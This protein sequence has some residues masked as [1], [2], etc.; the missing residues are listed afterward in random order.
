MFSFFKK[1]P[2][3]TPVPADAPAA[4][5][6]AAAEPGAEPAG[7]GWLRNPFAS[8][9]P[10]TPAAQ[11]AAPAVA[12]PAAAPPAAASAPPAGRTGWLLRLK[13]GLRKTGSS[14][15]TV[16][17]G[18]QIDDAL[19]EELE[20]ALLLA[21]TGVK[22]TGHLLA[23]LKRR[24]KE[25]RASDPAAVKAL[26]TEALAEL[27]RPLEKTLVIGA[28][29]PTVIMV[30]GVNGAG[31]TTSIG[32]LT[33]H[34]ADAGATVLLAAADT[35]RAAAREQLGVWADRNMV[36][37]VGQEG[38]DPAAVGFDAV[39]A[40]K[41]RGKDVVL[42]DTAGR[43]PTQL[44][45]M[46]EL[47]KIRRVIG[48]ADAGAPHEVL[49]VLDGNTG[50]NALA[51]V[52]AFDDALQLTGLIVTKLDGTAKGGV[53][54]AIAQERPI[55]VYFIGVGEKLEDLETFNAREFSQALLD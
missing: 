21:D 54:A 17:T 3:P 5:S 53:L 26:L 15:S 43:L 39:S 45:L 28:H 2:A 40:G 33:K 49:L 35:F 8:P 36:E 4:A 38:G 46:Q 18:T 25:R 7:L 34:L 9:A 23:E 24:A 44:H 51:Q 1:K 16:F 32:K 31:K 48:K 47:A 29:R 19:Y 50:Q 12:A 27:L 55:P 22:A 14:I 52:R 10:E 11:P 30:A 37:I 41:A 6:A 42:V 20:T 13:S